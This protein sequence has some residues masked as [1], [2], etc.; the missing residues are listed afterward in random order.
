MTS[1]VAWLIFI[2]VA[3]AF[4]FAAGHGVSVFVAFRLRGERDMD[5]QKALLDLSAYSLI[6]AGIALLVLLV[7]GIAAGIMLGSFGRWW[8]WI[9]LALL[10]VIGGLMTPLGA[11]YFTDVRRAVGQRT[12][13]MKADEPEPVPVAAEEL[14]AVLL[15]RR[16]EQLLVIGGGGFLVILWLMMF[17]PF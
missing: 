6:I 17:K 2:H 4:V 7:S 10:L 12:R 16:P 9:S 5:R 14:A 13:G 1:L 15:S 11:N 8:I 3:S